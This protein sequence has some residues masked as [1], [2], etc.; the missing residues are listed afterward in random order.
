MRQ[1]A[2]DRRFR[3]PQPAGNLR[4]AP[5]GSIEQD[6]NQPIG[7]SEPCQC[8]MDDR[9]VAGRVNVCRGVRCRGDV[10][11]LVLRQ[12]LEPSTTQPAMTLRE[13]QAPDPGGERRGLTELIE[14]F[15][16]E[17]EGILRRV[18]RQSGIAQARTGAGE[19]QI[20]EAAHEFSERVVA[21]GHGRGRVLR[22]LDQRAEGLIR[23]RHLPAKTRDA[24]VSCPSSLV[25]REGRCSMKTCVPMPPN[26]TTMMIAAPYAAVRGQRSSRAA[27][28]SN[29][30][31]RTRNHTGYRQKLNAF[32][33][34]LDSSN[35]SKPART[36]TMTSRSDSAHSRTSRPI[37]NA[38]L[39]WLT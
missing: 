12:Q 24:K 15:P 9:R 26:M 14:A 20:L 25:T 18:L 30:P 39:L 1:P 36:N 10:S 13:D 34:P 22:Q 28:S 31:I 19:R 32:A 23:S 4:L 7:G 5:L 21:F 2:S 37:R 16:R 35:L 33:Q 6:Q 29:T 27:P 8:E 11:R 17:Q 38:R 3:H